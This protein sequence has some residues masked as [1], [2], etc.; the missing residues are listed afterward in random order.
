MYCKKC[1]REINSDARYCPAC[2]AEQ[3][4]ERYD[5]SFTT[6]ISLENEKKPWKGWSIFSKI[7]WILSIVAIATSWVPV[8]IGLELGIPAIV[9][10]CLGRKAMT[11]IANQHGKIGLVLSIVAIVVSIFSYILFFVIVGLAAGSATYGVSFTQ[12]G[13]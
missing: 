9:F 13:Y 5:D 4:Q 6:T 10:C 8:F 3:T 11:D 1:G 2:G 12:G 7:G